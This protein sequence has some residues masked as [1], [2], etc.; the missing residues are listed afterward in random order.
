R[1]AARLPA[2]R[3]PAPPHGLR[4]GEVGLMPKKLRYLR[5]ERSFSPAAGIVHIGKNGTKRVRK[6]IF[7]E[8][9]K[10]VIEKIAIFITRK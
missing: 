7:F 2:Q 5:P 1:G 4:A 10:Q 9:R 6:K 8:T 3:P